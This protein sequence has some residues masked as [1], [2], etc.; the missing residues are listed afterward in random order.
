MS[1]LNKAFV[2]RV[3]KLRMAIGDV[4]MRATDAQCVWAVQANAG[5]HHHTTKKAARHQR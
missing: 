5:L 4:A 2:P 1:Y 3:D